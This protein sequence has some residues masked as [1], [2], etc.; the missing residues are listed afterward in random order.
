VDVSF[1]DMFV[2]YGKEWQD[3]AAATPDLIWLRG[4]R[5][6]GLY[7]R[8]STVITNGISLYGRGV[9]SNFA[10]DSATALT[11]VV[12]DDVIGAGAFLYAL[13]RFG[14]QSGAQHP[15]ADKADREWEAG[16][17]EARVFA[18]KFQ[19]FGLRIAGTVPSLDRGSLYRRR[20]LYDFERTG[21]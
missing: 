21:G 16:L 13:R 5:V 20:L 14:I 10:S 3:D 18:R 17:A 11:P 15:L 19:P 1:D 2:L 12:F 6:F 7:P 8:A 4:W 9:P